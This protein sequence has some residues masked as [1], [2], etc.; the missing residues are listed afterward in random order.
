MW[1][2]DGQNGWIIQTNVYA[3]LQQPSTQ[4]HVN[5]PLGWSGIKALV[6]N[7]GLNVVG[8]KLMT[9]QS[10]SMHYIAYKN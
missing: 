8:N 1:I 3:H 5:N 6:D 4:P 7:M 10:V 2:I 9:H